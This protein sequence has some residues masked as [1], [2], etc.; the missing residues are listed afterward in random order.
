SPNIY[1]IALY[2][3]DMTTTFLTA[4]TVNN[5][6]D[7]R[8]DGTSVLYNKGLPNLTYELILNNGTSEEVLVPPQATSVL[9]D[10]Y[11]QI[12]AGWVSYAKT[13]PSG[14]LQI[15][16]RDLT[17]QQSQLSFFGTG[18]KLDKLGDDGS[19]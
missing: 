14:V 6:F 4:D 3:P 15:W 5:N 2:K 17:G 7:V 9:A 12:A 19:I 1:N 8:T 10:Y 18:S 13:G 11:Y 16:R